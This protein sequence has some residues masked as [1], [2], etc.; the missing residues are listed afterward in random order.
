VPL[1]NEEVELFAPAKNVYHPSSF[2]FPFSQLQ[3]AGLPLGLWA[4]KYD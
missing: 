3:T 4:I 2:Q 1:A